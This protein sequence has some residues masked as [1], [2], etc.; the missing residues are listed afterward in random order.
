MQRLFVGEKGKAGEKPAEAETSR[1]SLGVLLEEYLREQPDTVSDSPAEAA[2]GRVEI[3]AEES[4]IS[5]NDSLIKAP[6]AL[7]GYR[8]QIFFG[9]LEQARQVRADYIRGNSS[10]SCVIRQVVPSYSV[11]VGDFRNT[12]EAYLRLSELKGL[13]P[14]A[15]VVP[16]EIDLPPLP[17][18]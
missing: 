5:L 12:Q 3:L 6:K 17:G 4:I 8:I 18:E 14:T 1:D 11:R 7:K 9:S 16:D 10:E 13:F 2:N 15:I